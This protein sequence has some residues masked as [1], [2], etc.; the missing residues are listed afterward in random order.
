MSWR[1][2]TLTDLKPMQT[3]RVNGGL[4][5]RIHG[6]QRGAGGEVQVLTDLSE[7]L[8]LSPADHLLRLEKVAARRPAHLAAHGLA[9]DRQDREENGT[10]AALT[11]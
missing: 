2:V 9:Q 4:A 6:V 11:P 3:V 10:Q 8:C 5:I 1:P 7:T